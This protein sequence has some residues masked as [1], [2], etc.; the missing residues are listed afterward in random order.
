MSDIGWDVLN[1]ESIFD[2]HF[3]MI[4]AKYVKLCCKMLIDRKNGPTEG[5]EH[6]TFG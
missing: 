5:R 6:M 4:L 3:G 1:P 2:F